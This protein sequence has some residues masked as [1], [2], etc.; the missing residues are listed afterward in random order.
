MQ[1]LISGI[2][3]STIDHLWT[4]LRYLQ[5][6]KI[7]ILAVSTTNTVNLMFN[8]TKMAKATN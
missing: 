5:T 3:P 2:F 8:S 4:T 1:L 7:K 6:T